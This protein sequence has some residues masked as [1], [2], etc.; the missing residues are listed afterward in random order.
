MADTLSTNLQ[1]L[2]ASK[3][4][5]TAP[6]T[7]T[8]TNPMPFD[9]KSC[10]DTKQD[11]NAYL[12][13]AASTAYPGMIVAVTSSEDPEKGAYVISSNGT[14]LVPVLLGTKEEINS[15]S[16]SAVINWLDSDGNAIQ[17]S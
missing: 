6:C 13:D 17:E 14:N 8:R 12:A 15:A 11:L 7:F 9:P 2:I 10:F 5:W 1:T 16:A 3:N 4:T